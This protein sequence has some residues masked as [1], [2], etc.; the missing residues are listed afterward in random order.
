MCVGLSVCVGLMCIY[1]DVNAMVC[2]L[3]FVVLCVVLVVCCFVSL[4][5]CVCC[6]YVLCVWFCFF[7]RAFVCVCVGLCVFLCLRVPF[8]VV[9]CVC[10]FFV[11]VYVHN[12][13]CDGLSVCFGFVYT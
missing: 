3:F 8:C 12:C 1:I 10:C 13:V 2:S 11:C 4:I 9:C 7:G 5:C 6:D